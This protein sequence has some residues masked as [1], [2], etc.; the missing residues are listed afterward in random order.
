MTNAYT[1]IKESMKKTLGSRMIDWRASDS[2]VKV[3]KPIDIGRARNL[4]YK[5]KKGFVILRVRVNRGGR[6]RPRPRKGRRSK[7]MHV[8]LVLKMNYQWVA[9]GRAQRKYNNLEVL[10]SYQVGK[11]GKHYFYEVIMVDPHK[12][13]VLNDNNVSWIARGTNK[14]RALRGLTS[15]GKKSRGLRHKGPQKKTGPSARANSRRGR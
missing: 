13:E 1:Y 6:Q 5:D 8:K 3:D 12:A 15:A 14:N 4:G 7:R 10:N 11:D 9:E 2:V